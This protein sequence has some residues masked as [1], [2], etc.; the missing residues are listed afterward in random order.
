M[1]NI[2]KAIRDAMVSCLADGTTGFNAQLD[3]IASAY[4][5]TSFAI[6][7]T[8]DSRNF[9]QAYLDPEMLDVSR[10]CE[11]PAAVLYLAE[12]VNER[13]EK[14]RS[15]SGQVLGHLDFYLRYRLLKDPQTAGN[16]TPP[17]N[18][19]YES[20]ADAVA[21]AAMESFIDGAAT[22]RAAG[23]LWSKEYRIDRDPVQLFG[24]GHG[25]RIAIT[26]GFD[27]HI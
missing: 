1:P 20:A 24:D 6:D 17:S 26:L 3:D 27:R 7:W 8:S 11:F 4:G 5:I 9:V 21:D 12:A 23:A 14:Y 15:F 13:R 16:D 18:D 25:Q 2:Y 19:D 10:V 22:L